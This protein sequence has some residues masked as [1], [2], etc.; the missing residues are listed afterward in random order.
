MTTSCPSFLRGTAMRVTRLDACGR[1]VYGDGNMVVS[2]GFVTATLSAEVQEGDAITVTKANGQTC[3]NEPGEDQL[4]WYTTQIEFCAVDPD[5]VQIM[6]QSWDKVVDAQGN[7]I[8]YNANGSLSGDGFALEIWM[9]VY[10]TG[11]AC[12]GDQAQGEWGYILLPWVKGGAPG[13]IE[14]GNDAI[15]FTYNGKTKVG[16]GWRRGPY[17]VQQQANGAPGPLLQPIGSNTHYRLFTTTIRPPE[18]ECGAQPVDRPTPEVAELT[19]TGVPGETPRNTVRLRADNHGFGPVVINWGDGT[20]ETIASDGAYITHT[21]AAPGTQTIQ[22]RDQQTP[23]VSVSKEIT[24]P[25]PADE[26]GLT[27]SAD[28]PENRYAV[29]A[30][31]TL[32]KQAS[33]TATVDWGDGTDPVTVTV[34]ADG[35]V[36]STHTY[37]AA[38]VYTV[39]VRRS[40]VETYR[41][42]A[43]V[44]VPVQASPTVTAEEDTTDATA[45]TVKLTW[46]NGTNGPVSIDWGDGS[47]PVDQTQTGTATHAY[48]TNG[49]K[50]ITVTSK[51]NPA[52]STQATATI[53]FP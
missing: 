11:D 36:S 41:T 12:S 28:S 6:N 50:T 35:T 49:V 40:D 52:A 51:A 33:G 13:D 20:A 30:A 45:K 32:P 24:V 27:L 15:S 3:I 10:G 34:G 8:G 23:A 48:T 38:G 16:S 44:A 37:K 42:R 43:A 26:P 2:D 29:T 17:P 47:A 25:L 21:Y 5:L 46:D 14:I 19:I 9:D 18:P 4:Q 22:V 1:P 7:V 39:S 31:I 53:P